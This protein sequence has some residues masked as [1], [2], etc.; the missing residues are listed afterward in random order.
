MQNDNFRLSNIA[1][2][3]LSALQGSAISQTILLEFSSSIAQIEPLSEKQEHFILPVYPA[4]LWAKR[5]HTNAV[6][7]AQLHC[8]SP[9]M[10]SR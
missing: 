3:S 8:H 1:R 10:Y 5:P 7:S 2:N 4:L 9:C 6:T